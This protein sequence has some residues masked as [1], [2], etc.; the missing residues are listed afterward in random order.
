MPLRPSAFTLDYPFDE[1][2]P[3][4]ID[5]SAL[6]MALLGVNPRDMDAAFDLGAEVVL[7]GMAG[8]GTDLV[9][10]AWQFAAAFAGLL[11]AVVCCTGWLCRRRRRQSGLASVAEKGADG[12]GSTE[13]DSPGGRG[14]GGEG[15]LED[16]LLYATNERKGDWGAAG[17]ESESDDEGEGED[18]DWCISFERNASRM[19]GRPCPIAAMRAVLEEAGLYVQWSAES[20]LPSSPS[21]REPKGRWEHVFLQVGAPDMVLLREASTC[22]HPRRVVGVQGVPRR[23]GFIRLRGDGP[24]PPGAVKRP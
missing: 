3:P 14:S 19:E 12:Y 20:G 16:P 4:H 13:L 2:P 18:Y 6:G 10:P 15:E 23:H 21:S 24:G 17:A 7:P 8:G 9:L 11:G 1:R 22:G 5:P